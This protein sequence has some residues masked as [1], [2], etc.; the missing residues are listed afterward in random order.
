MKQIIKNNGT[1][2]LELLL[3]QQVAN[4]N[5]QLKGQELAD[6]LNILIADLLNLLKNKREISQDVKDVQNEVI[7]KFNSLSE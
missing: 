7:T 6:A 3:A 5:E 4:E 1:E 2:G